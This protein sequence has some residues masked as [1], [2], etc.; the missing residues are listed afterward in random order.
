M[1]DVIADEVKKE[2]VLKSIE[3]LGFKSFADRSKIEFRD[4]ISAILGPNGCGKSNIVDAIKWV[5]GEQ[6]TKTLRADKM[7]DVIFNGTED[8][9]AMSVA[10]VT[11]VLSND[12]NILDIELSEISIKRRLYRSGESEYLINNNPVKLKDIRELFFDTGIGKSAYSIM[13]QGKID[14]ILSNKPEERRLLFEEAA[15]IT[16]YKQKSAEAERKLEK[17]E[18]N[19]QQVDSILREVKRSYDSLKIQ[20]E[21]TKSYRELKEEQFQVELNIQLVKLA[22]FLESKEK[23][24]QDQ[25]KKTEERN[26]IRRTIN[27]LNN[28]LESSLDQVNSME[29]KLIET[30]KT[31]YGLDLEKNNKL[32]QIELLKERIEEYERQARANLAREES[33][34]EKISTFKRQLEDK[35]KTLE[36]IEKR[37]TEITENIASFEEN[38]QR[39]NERIRTNEKQIQKNEQEILELENEQKSLQSELQVITDDIVHQLDLGLKESG[40]SAKERKKAEDAFKEK[41]SSA[42]IHI[43]GKAALLKDSS[44]LDSS[45]RDELIQFNRAAVE[46]LED[47]LLVLD[48]I[49]TLYD[50]YT[51]T[52]PAF[53]DEF[54][55][56]QGIITQKRELDD[57]IMDTQTGITQRRNSL[58]QLREEISILSKKIE[59]YRKTLE[60]LRMNRV[61]MKTQQSGL[62]DTIEALQA[63]LL[64]Q[65]KTLE[66]NQ[67]EIKRL[68]EEKESTKKKIKEAEK[69]RA[70]LE[71]REGDL[72]KELSTLEKGI[73][74]KNRDLLESE[75]KIK[76]LRAQEEALQGRLEKVQMECAEINAEIRNI[77][78]NFRE[79]HSRDLTEYEDRMFEIKTPLQELRSVLQEKKSKIRELGQVNLMALEEFEEIKERY[80]FLSGQMKDLTEAKEDL[81]RITTQI[82]KE[83]AELFLETYNQVRKNFHSMFRRLFGGGRAELQLLDPENILETGVEIFAQPP[84]KNLKNIS[85]L[86][87]GERSLTA[88][89]LL[90][91]T[92]MVKPSPFCLLDEIDAALDENN[93][94]QFVHLLMEFGKKSQFIIITHNKK[95][96]TGANTLIGI[97]MAEPGVSKVVS[98]RIDEYRERQK[99]PEG[100][101]Q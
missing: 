85:L 58:N 51:A 17:T 13:E 40:Y 71:Q 88:V 28:S 23:K 89:G 36:E 6:A 84:G 79:N 19:M 86:S 2:L 11:L 65:K 39:A 82:R 50:S 3:L 75:K 26:G 60:E 31:L 95:T 45:S 63:D 18:E 43:R 73:H 91:A 29:T 66:E 55:A 67:R 62:H 37:L 10:E 52:I 33:I 96:V 77:Y 7:E 54:I 57:K 59:E 16:K 61:R 24:E 93:V 92:Y 98:V 87:G 46:S 42:K 30:Q 5:L 70:E 9:R 14:Q 90:F 15:G 80:D 1:L 101:L 64:E 69:K 32:S 38:I 4:G 81:E 68:E 22:G 12:E 83:S 8:R 78:D 27:G 44:Q 48:D 56:P 47:A 100:I 76:S 49:N 41:I 99:E 34:K 21:K 25:N 20:A 53:I 94:G 97:T 74:E 72:Q 35:K